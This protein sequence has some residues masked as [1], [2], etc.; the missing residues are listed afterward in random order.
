MTRLDPK[1]MSP[2][3]RAQLAAKAPDAVPVRDPTKRRQGAVKA[4]GY[5]ATRCTRCTD[6]R[7]DTQAAEDHH[8]A[9]TGHGRYELL[10]DG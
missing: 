1:R 9:D 6:S 2:A 3:M 7:F 8:F 4:P 5:S 10:L